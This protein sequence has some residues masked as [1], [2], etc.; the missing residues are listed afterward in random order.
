[1]D[2]RLLQFNMKVVGDGIVYNFTVLFVFLNAHIMCKFYLL[3][4]KVKCIFVVYMFTCNVNNIYCFF[5]E[6]I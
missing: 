4:I 1:M 2:I 5:V 6:G 3:N